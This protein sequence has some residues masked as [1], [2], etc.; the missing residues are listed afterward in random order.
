MYSQLVLSRSEYSKPAIGML[1][2]LRTSIILLIA[3][4]FYGCDNEVVIPTVGDEKVFT[5]PSRELDGKYDVI[6][7]ITEKL[8]DLDRDGKF[9]YNILREANLQNDSL[10]YFAQLSTIKLAGGDKMFYQQVY[11]WVPTTGIF[12]D[13][14][15]TYLSTGYA[16]SGILGYFRYYSNTGVIKLVEKAYNPAGII[17][18][19]KLVNG[20]LTLTIKQWYYTTNAWE[21]LIV[22]GTYQRRI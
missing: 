2:Y 15:G 13:D 21:E 16:V 22:T 7:L 5:N 8:V 17:L 3:P 1:K 14:K 19:A 4:F 10:K 20:K 12:V 6:S 18:D 9:S 11:M